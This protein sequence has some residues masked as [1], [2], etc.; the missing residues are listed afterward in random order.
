VVTVNGIELL[1]DV[2]RHPGYLRPF[3]RKVLV[4]YHIA[5]AGDSDS[6]D[7]DSCDSPLEPNSPLYGVP[8]KMEPEMLVP[9]CSNSID[10]VVHFV[11]A[12]VLSFLYYALDSMKSKTLALLS[13]EVLT[14]CFIQPGAGYGICSSTISKKR[15]DCCCGSGF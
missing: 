12:W 1:V 8:D 15:A 10:F 9:T 13:S 4:M 14:F 2:M 6:A 3:S 11:C 7:Y 5:G